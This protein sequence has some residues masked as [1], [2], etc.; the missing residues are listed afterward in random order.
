MIDQ[1]VDNKSVVEAKVA[2]VFSLVSHDVRRRPFQAL[3]GCCSVSLVVSFVASLLGVFNLINP[4]FL[5][6]NEETYSNSDFLLLPSYG[7]VTLDFSSLFLD[8]EIVDKALSDLAQIKGATPRWYIPAKAENTNRDQANIFL[9]MGNSSKE[10]E[11]GLGRAAKLGELIEDEAYV[12]KDVIESLGLNPNQQFKLKIPWV[13]MVTDR[14]GI[15]DNELVS[16]A[17]RTISDRISQFSIPTDFLEEFFRD[18]R[19]IELEA[20]VGQ[21]VENP[22]GKWPSIMGS[23]VFV[24]A[25]YFL[26][27]AYESIM[28]RAIKA[29]IQKGIITQE[30]WDS[31]GESIME[32][33]EDF[34]QP[35]TRTM[36]MSILVKNKLEVY[37]NFKNFDDK[38]MRISNQ[39]MLKLD[40]PL[41]YQLQDPNTNGFKIMG[42][43]SMVIQN[44]IACVFIMMAIVGYFVL[45]SLTV[46]NAEEKNHEFDIVRAIGATKTFVRRVLIIQS[47]G[48]AVIG[49]LIGVGLNLLICKL[50]EGSI[51]E[52]T[53]LPVTTKLPV[54][55]NLFLIGLL[56]ILLPLISTLTSLS[57]LSDSLTDSGRS[58]AIKV[59]IQKLK[60]LQFSSPAKIVMGLELSIFGF[61]F[62][63]LAPQAFINQRIDLFLLM[64]TSV[65]L[66]AIIGMV[67][68]ATSLRGT[69]QSLL[70][71]S[72]GRWWKGWKWMSMLIG[73]DKVSDTKATLKTVWLVVAL[74][75]CFVMFTGSGIASQIGFIKNMMVIV[76]GGDLV[77][78]RSNQKDCLDEYKLRKLLQDH[79]ISKDIVQSYSFVSFP[80][81]NY[82]RTEFLVPGSYST[83]KSSIK[84][85][86]SNYMDTIDSRSYRP[87]YQ[88]PQFEKERLDSG[89]FN[90]LKSIFEEQ[91]PFM[92]ETDPFKIISYTDQY[93]PS[94]YKQKIAKG[95]LSSG[96]LDLLGVGL[97]DVVYIDL[98]GSRFLK[99]NFT[100]IADKIPGLRFSSYRT[101][102]DDDNDVAVSMESFAF[103]LDNVR[104]DANHDWDNFRVQNSTYKVPKEKVIIKLKEG[105]TDKQRTKLKNEIRLLV[106]SMDLVLDKVQIDQ[107]LSKMTNALVA[108]DF[109]VTL[110]FSFLCLFLMLIGTTR[111]V[112]QSAQEIGMFKSIGLDSEQVIF[113]FRTEIFSGM[114]SAILIGLILG[115]LVSFVAAVT[116]ATIFEA[117]I[118][119]HFP[120][121]E[122]LA[123]IGSMVISS[124]V[125]SNYGL[126][127][128][129]K[130]NI[131]KLLKGK[132]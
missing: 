28:D 72:V 100:H 130:A 90:G 107:G 125:S 7:D 43:L 93:N 37:E 111:R 18:N 132:L 128:I 78:I 20:K 3:I 114:I 88:N 71:K 32:R 68:L 9:I 95:A 26:R 75:V 30:M 83:L 113:L 103:I 33:I 64:L 66:S 29:A 58:S 19:E 65:L 21:E 16:L 112:S 24:E 40:E 54:F 27:Q 42:A 12:S 6:I 38:L 121:I 67:V 101:V 36:T 25:S 53:N 86:E 119:F 13:D 123:L 129:R 73:G 87:L 59:T 82:A 4:L 55:P 85:I 120:W 31:F 15:L 8:T 2:A 46:L 17:A 127:K 11:L 89:Q 117:R 84:G 102:V 69:I 62:Y 110:L 77:V 92:E 96:A 47:M 108:F 44:I 41:K 74:V 118:D 1:E 14:T 22:G 105:T 56:G 81:E 109:V 79:Q 115:L 61:V 49:T 60:D 91:P 126:N 122:I 106:D 76:N 52:Y 51:R 124:I 131:G 80:L 70:I 23:V 57:P 45:S 98:D 116:T 104:G 48:L 99:I 39:I 50:I 5:S 63:Y 94:S 34:V 10:I 35:D 97:N